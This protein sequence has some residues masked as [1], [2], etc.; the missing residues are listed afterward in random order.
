MTA[1]VCIMNKLGVAL[2]ADSALTLGSQPGEVK[3]YSSADKIFQLSANA[4]V[5]MMIYGGAEFLGVPWETIIKEFRR[6]LAR[7]SQTTL[8]CYAEKFL[9][10]LIDERLFPKAD[11]DA[12]MMNLVCAFLQELLNSIESRLD[13]KVG[14]GEQPTSE[15]IPLFF[16]NVLEEVKQEILKGQR[17][18]GFSSSVVK[19]I[20]SKYQDQIDK[21][22]HQV[23]QNLPLSENNHKQ[24]NAIAIEVVSR[25]S[26]SP[27]RSGVVIAGFGDTEFMPRAR[28]F[29]VDAVVSGRLRFVREADDD[30]SQENSALIRPFAQQEM[31]HTFMRGIDPEYFRFVQS[32][33]G[34]A[35]RGIVDQIRGF[36][37]TEDAEQTKKIQSHLD[38]ESDRLV[39]GLFSAWEKRQAEHWRPVLQIVNALPKDELA[40]MAE[41]LVNLTK[42][43]RR[44]TTDR[45][46][47][48][49][50]VDVAIITRGDGFV[51]VNRKHYFQPELNPRVMARYQQG[52]DNE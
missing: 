10:F 7:N 24:I 12:S 2:A 18:E 13:T 20:R 6:G 26:I 29:E 38:K 25:R 52:T 28:S 30:I 3:V 33:A 45:E 48:G 17:L 16:E 27:L 9:R 50:P 35:I 21:L 36:I 15:D 11:Q 1:E 19:S 43:R 44:V 23:F 32:T 34:D 8:D 51:W 42:F 37:S 31:V 5:G 22:G 39:Q 49:G 41:A 46:T 40:A 14:A 4:P 47:V